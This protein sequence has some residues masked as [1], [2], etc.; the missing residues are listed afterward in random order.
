MYTHTHAHTHTY[1]HTHTHT[2]THTAHTH[3]HTHMYNRPEEATAKDY[4]FD[5]YAHHGIHHEMLS[6]RVR[7]GCYR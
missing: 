2:H 1:T 5:S 7:T 6:D 4:Y 3:T